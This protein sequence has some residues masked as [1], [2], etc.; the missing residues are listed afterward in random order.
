MTPLVLALLLITWG[1]TRDLFGLS[2]V[3]TGWLLVGITLFSLLPVILVIL[4]G[5]A[6]TGGTVEVGTVKIALTAAATSQHVIVVPSN[7]TQLPGTPIGDSGSAQ[8]LDALEKSRLSDIVV[9][10]LEDGH[11]WWETRL[12]ILCAGAV[13]LGRPALI[14]FTAQKEGRPGQ[15]IGW[16]PPLDLRDA[17]LRCDQRYS[18]AFEAAMG[19]AAAAHLNG[20]AHPI[21]TE[22]PVS[23]VIPANK[24][25]ILYPKPGVL[26][27]FLEEQILADSLGNLES[28]GPRE[29][30][31]GRLDLF[32]SFLRTSA[33]ESTDRE[34]DWFRSVLLNDDTFVAV[35]DHGNYIAVMTR[36]AIFNTVLL[37]L[38]Q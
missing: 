22:K 20:A 35:T 13:R 27:P 7:V 17:L 18:E 8:I 5:V 1:L 38:T 21:G 15:F 12:L 14:V 16:A 11:S 24:M 23:V 31:I 6:S 28:S 34:A 4:E 2:T 26:N 25:H 3:S 36:T 30:G 33:I 10:D 32:S 9:V 37:A 29:I 19:L